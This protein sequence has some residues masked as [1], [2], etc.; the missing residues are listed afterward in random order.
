MSQSNTKDVTRRKSV[1]PPHVD[2]KV[3]RLE[4]L[5]MRENKDDA[6]HD[7][8]MLVVDVKDDEK[9]TTSQ[10]DNW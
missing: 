8:V 3:K 1:R 7:D 4:D 9:T 5:G 10:Q 2:L 6:T